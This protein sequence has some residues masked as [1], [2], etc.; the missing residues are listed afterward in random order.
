MFEQLE[1]KVRESIEKFEEPTQIQG[2]FLGP[3]K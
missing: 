2:A 3:T 1:D